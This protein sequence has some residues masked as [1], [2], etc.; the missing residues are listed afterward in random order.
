MNR[1]KKE[2]IRK[3][4]LAREGLSP[5]QITRL[6]VEDERREKIEKLAK[7]IHAKKFP[8]EYDFG[9]DSFADAKNRA[10]G[11]NPM[12]QDYIEKVNKK[13]ADLGV[14]PL[15][16]SGEATSNDTMKMCLKD[17]EDVINGS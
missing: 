2:E 11:I 17:A 4:Q 1:W 5:A 3:K 15:S 8:E 9:Y 14:A 12:S 6:D 10:R 7:K 13:R 16:E